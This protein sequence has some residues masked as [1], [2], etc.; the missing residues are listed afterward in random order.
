MQNR[1]KKAFTL[2][3]VLVTLAIIGVIA[4]LVIPSLIANIEKQGYISRLQRA[5]AAGDAALR[6]AALE[7]CGTTDLSC[8]YTGNALTIGDAI[9]AQYNVLKNCK[10]TSGQGCFV[11]FNSYIDGTGGILDL[12]ND[13]NYYKFITT[14]GMSVAIQ[15]SSS[16]CTTNYG[17]NANSPTTKTCG[18][19]YVDLN[20]PDKGPN[21]SGK[22]V[23]WFLVTSNKAPIMYPQGGREH[24]YTLNGTEETGGYYYWNYNNLNRCYNAGGKKGGW[25]CTGRIIE[26]GWQIDY[27]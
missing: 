19:F 17:L 1:N 22:D 16:K 11:V 25:M 3:E 5:M 12:D 23:F 20:G 26:K 15:R 14:D 2:A 21:Y 24:N 4:S 27:Y 13:S 18:Q 6:K 9:A 8:I 10:N 7:N